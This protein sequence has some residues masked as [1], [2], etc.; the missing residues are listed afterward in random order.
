MGGV[1]SFVRQDYTTVLWGQGSGLP[2]QSVTA[3]GELGNYTEF[4][5]EWSFQRNQLRAPKQTFG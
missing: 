5:N 3:G 4:P 1:N 2:G